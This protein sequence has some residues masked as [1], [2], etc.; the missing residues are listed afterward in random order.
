MIG[1]SRNTLYRLC[2]GHEIPGVRKVGK[3]WRFHR[4]TLLNFLACKSPQGSTDTLI[5]D[6]ETVSDRDL[7]RAHAEFKA[8]YS[9]LQAKHSQ[10]QALVRELAHMLTTSWTCALSPRA[11]SW[12]D[13][14]SS[15]SP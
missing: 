9:D 10:T 13:R 12:I 8:Q 14:L 15:S 6:S 2:K 7:P 1:V 3:S 11:R 5:A 4:E